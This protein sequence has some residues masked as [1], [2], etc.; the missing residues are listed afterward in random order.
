[1]ETKG[2]LEY[3]IF[4]L[5][6][7][8]ML[9]REVRYSTLHDAVYAAMHCADEFRRRFLDEREDTARRINGDVS[10]DSY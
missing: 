6:H 2:E 1:L 10:G 4:W 5:M 9:D 3:V 8:F 7:R